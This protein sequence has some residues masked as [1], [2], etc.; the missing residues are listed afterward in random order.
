M[1]HQALYHSWENHL[2]YLTLIFHAK[3][4]TKTTISHC[5][6]ITQNVTFEFLIWIFSTNF[7][8][9]KTDLSGITV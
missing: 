3:K 1:M 7:C 4:G 2:K 5:L 9:I 6:K 8:P